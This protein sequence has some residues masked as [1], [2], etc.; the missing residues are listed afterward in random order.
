MTASLW[1]EHYWGWLIFWCIILGVPGSVAEFCRRALR[2]R[3]K[4]KIALIKARGRTSPPPPVAA[5]S[6]EGQRSVTGC[7]HLKV[8]PVRLADGTLVRWVCANPV[9]S[10]EFPPESAILAEED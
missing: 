6:A 9:C 7:P 4:R 5:L 2:T 8:V 10:R 3:H 1:L